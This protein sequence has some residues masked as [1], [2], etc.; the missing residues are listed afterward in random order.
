MSQ[1][2][3]VKNEK[4]NN[5]YFS[6]RRLGHANL[7]VSDYGR[8]ADFYKKVV[9]FEEV[10]R[11][12]DN[13]ASFL[14]NGNTYHDLALT[15]IHSKYAK[16]DQKPGMWHLAFEL[17]TEVDMVDGYN[18]AKADGVP[19]S[20][21]M[22]HDVARSLYQNDPDGNLVE[23]YADVEKDWRSMRQGIIVKEKP[24]WVPGIT[25]VPLT[26]KNYPQDPQLVVVKDSIFHPKKVAHVALVADKFEDMF[27]YY[28]NVVGL[29]LLFGDRQADSAVL[30]GTSS[31]GDVTLYRKNA[32]LL[33]GLHHVGF[34]VWDDADLK[35]SIAAL[36]GSGV[37][38]ER[39]VDHPSRHSVVIQD[40][41]GL[42]L[43]FFVNR[44]WTAD[45]IGKA[46]ADELP[47]L[48]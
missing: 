27:D 38:V 42:L 19:F 29:S 32:N 23:I 34:E 30:R 45:V 15:D 25:S 20:F 9:G 22:D 5:N 4:K 3:E 47:Y 11:Q 17:E 13:Q 43:Q 36:P 40:M 24:K 37:K 28:V 26:E 7:F 39:E 16:K 12:P 33:P 8:A 35:H 21:V 41:D 46:R 18:R 10:Y 6:P 44:N 31:D 14:S 48:L 2:N 1:V